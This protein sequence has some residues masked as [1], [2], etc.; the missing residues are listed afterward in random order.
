MARESNLVHALDVFKESGVWVYGLSVEQGIPLWQ[1]DLTGPLCLV[2]G[3]EGEGVR[4][5]V[6][7][8]CDVTLTIPMIGGVGSLNVSAAGAIACYEVQRQRT[9]ARGGR[10]D[11]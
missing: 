6:A 3:S 9:A 4:R 5:L 8:T 2:L 1:A 7:R 11:A 10:P